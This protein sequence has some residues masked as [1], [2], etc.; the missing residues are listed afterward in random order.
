MTAYHILQQ[1]NVTRLCHFTK[2]Q[3]FTHIISSENG[4]LSSATIGPDTKNLTDPARYD[5]EVEHVCCSVQYPNSWFL[6]KSKGRNTDSIFS[7][8]V[9]IY[10]SLDVLNYREAKFSPCN[11]SK[12]YGKYINNNMEEIESIFSDR[13]PTF[14]YRRT[15]EMLSYCPTDGQAEIQIHHNIPRRFITGI[16]VNEE[17]LAVRVHTVFELC[18]ITEIPIYIAPDI[19]SKKWSELIKKGITPDE[20]RYDIPK[21]S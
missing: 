21:E 20:I 2:F 10:I 17:D 16:A 19:M 9:V 3:K 1:R 13:V 11:A 6:T 7:E 14:A 4:I 8:W 12:E 5:G 15:K 18:N